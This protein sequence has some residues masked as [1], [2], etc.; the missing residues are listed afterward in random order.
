MCLFT[1]ARPNEMAQMHLA[2]L[3]RTEKDTWYLDIEA[4]DDEDE[5][6]N[7]AVKTLKTAA[8]RRT[9]PLHPE[10]LKIGFVQFVAQRKKASSDPRLFP[11]LKADGYGNCA[12]YA[13]KRFREVYLPGAIKL[14][15]RQSFYSFRHSWR[16]ALRRIDAPADTLQ[17]VG[18]WSQGKT[19]D[20][21]GDP[22][23]ADLQFKIIRKIS[24]PGLDLTPLHAKSK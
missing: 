21:Y 9:I 17:A 2:D 24:F 14:A 13:L 10:L 12:T 16:D 5:E 22:N 20:S 3:K 15:P 19:S 4:T 23:D 18:G 8:S 6:V 1:G 7:G 11:D